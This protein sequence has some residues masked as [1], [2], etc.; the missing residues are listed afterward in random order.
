MWRNKIRPMPAPCSS[1]ATTKSALRKVRV[2]ARARR[3]IGGQTVRAMAMTAFSM[4]GPRLAEKARARTRLG[5]ER[6]ISVIR[7]NTIST[8]PPR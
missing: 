8:H 1:A 3:A 6:K 5:K 2:S 7:I 4:P